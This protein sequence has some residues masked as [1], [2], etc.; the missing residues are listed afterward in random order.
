MA[1]ELDF[2]VSYDRKSVAAELGRV[3]EKLGKRTLTW[4]DIDR[5]ELP[6]DHPQ[7]GRQRR[8]VHDFGGSE[9]QHRPRRP[10]SRRGSP[11]RRDP[12]HGHR[13]S[14]RKAGRDLRGLRTGR[15][16][17][18]PKVRRDGP[19]SDHHLATGR[20]DGW[21]C[22]GGE[23][24]QSREYLSLHGLLERGPAPRAQVGTG[25]PVG[26]NGTVLNHRR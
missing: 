7:S 10:Q 22:L 3:A 2:L 18:Q 16:I 20:H 11:S 5:H 8:Q 4:L 13:Y 19:G 25:N 1:Y 9:Y 14:H 12:R 26:R 6:T 17:A 15:F 21:A 24:A 23:P